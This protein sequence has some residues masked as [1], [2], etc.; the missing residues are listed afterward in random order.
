ML[1]FDHGLTRLTIDHELLYYVIPLYL[2]TTLCKIIHVLLCRIASCFS[3]V[4]SNFR[5]S[6]KQKYLPL[7]VKCNTTNTCNRFIIYIQ[8][9]HIRSPNSSTN[10]SS[11]HRS[12]QLAF[13][14][15]IPSSRCPALTQTL[16]V[17]DTPELYET[18]L[19]PPQGVGL[20][21]SERSIECRYWMG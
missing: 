17:H 1:A 12:S 16:D 19:N 9:R 14:V 20:E 8:S 6:S 15:H 4:H 2:T 7:C 21:K 3:R 18:S 11:S 5:L 13:E 10:S